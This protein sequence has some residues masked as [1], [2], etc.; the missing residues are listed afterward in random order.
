MGIKQEKLYSVSEVA[1]ILGISRTHVLRKIA[2]G[3]IQADKVGKSYAIAASRLPGIH[4][5]LSEQDKKEV[6][7][8]VE[9]TL[10]EYGEVIRKLGST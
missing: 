4:R 6:E 10:K 7:K 9:K 3:E 8:A 2:A 1:K 5:P